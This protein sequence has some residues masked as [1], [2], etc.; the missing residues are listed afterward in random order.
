MQVLDKESFDTYVSVSKR[1]IASV[2]KC[3]Q[4]IDTSFSIPYSSDGIEVIFDQ[5]QVVVSYLSLLDECCTRINKLLVSGNILVAD[6]RARVYIAKAELM[7]TKHQVLVNKGYSQSEREA[8]INI[9]FFE[10]ERQ[11]RLVSNQVKIVDSIKWDILRKTKLLTE[12]L[13]VLRINRELLDMG[14]GMGEK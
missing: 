11:I 14:I 3:L 13:K 4:G 7:R 8:E 2:K 12:T 9:D 6:A 1:E 5:A 10:D